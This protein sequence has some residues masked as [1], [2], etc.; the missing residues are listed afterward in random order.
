VWFLDGNTAGQILAAQT[1]GAVADFPATAVGY[2]YPAG[3]WLFLDGGQLNLGVVRDG[4][5]STNRAKFFS[6][7]F[8][9]A[10]LIGPASWE[11]TVTLGAHGTRS[12]LTAFDAT[13][14]G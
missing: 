14:G 10:H 6:E 3:S 11:L 4:L 13:P 1:A 7:T 12:A 8:E 2:M 9:G 5:V